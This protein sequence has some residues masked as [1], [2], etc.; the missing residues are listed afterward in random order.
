MAQPSD[1][2]TIA[3]TLTQE[4]LQEKRTERRWKNIRS[5]AWLILFAYI[6]FNLFHAFLHFNAIGSLDTNHTEHRSYVALIRLEGMIAPDNSFSSEAVIPLLKKA[7]AD[8]EA[9]GIILDINS[10]GGTPVQA[11][12][13]HDA[14]LKLKQQY[15]KHVVVVGEDLLTSGA[16]YVAVASD[17]IY[18]NA[19][20]LTGSIGVIMKGFGF[21]DLMKKIG[22]E[23][24]VYTVG[25]DKDRLDPFL[26][27]STTD[28]KKI[29]QVMNEVHNNFVQ[30][31]LTGRKGKL[32]AKPAILFTGD[33]WSG[34]SAL[35]LGLAD[36]LGNLMDVAEKE[37]H[38]TRFK[39]YSHTNTVLKL[40]SEHFNT[41]LDHLFFNF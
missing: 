11:A 19:N 34:P 10:P 37:F 41:A 14:I 12:I 18:I 23:R 1:T 39:Q 7:F 22:I 25:S 16:Y 4:L 17:K 5:F 20:T 3:V 24:R 28:I 35:K 36:G 30:A 6:C 2:D 33:F 15:K 13:I 8:N 27:Q 26:P 21:V 9:V 40:L 29:N 38:T 31:V 32:T